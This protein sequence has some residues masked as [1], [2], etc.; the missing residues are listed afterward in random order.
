M[1]DATPGSAVESG[2]D[3]VAVIVPCYNEAAT[4]ADVIGGFRAALPEARIVVYDNNSTDDTA[5]RAL[6]AGAEVR[7]ERRQGKGY[8]VRRAFADI[9]A[10][11][12]V[13]VDGDATYDA[14]SAPGMVTRLVDERLDMIVGRRRQAAESVWRA[15]HRFGNR[16]LT[17][18]VQRLFGSDMRDMLSG[19]R[20]FSRRFVK[21]FPAMSRE[22]EIETELT[23][24]A[25]ELQLPVA[26]CDTPYYARPEGSHSKLETWRDG[27]RILFSILR[28][29]MLQ[30]P[31]RLFA[32]MAAAVFA[33]ASAL[34]APVFVE[35]L[36]T[37]LVPRL[38]TAIFAAT[39]YAMSFVG[40]VL[41]VVLHAIV[42]G[43]IET[44]RLAWLALGSGPRR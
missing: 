44:K 40:V 18:A 43:R 37:G 28:L 33:A 22:F 20:V 14:P 4:V 9:E 24:H 39:A 41:G 19:Y 7:T 29:F 6:A 10:E 36:K 5:A 8:A 23:V 42:I 3:A 17:S 31:F 2:R 11:I 27:F 21:S 30:R 35:Y 1:N 26:E 34:F 38:P 13:L 15:H 12:Y 16:L 32:I 25:L